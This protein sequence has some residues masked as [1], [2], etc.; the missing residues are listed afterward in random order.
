M[1]N[2]FQQDQYILSHSGQYSIIK[3]YLTIIGNH[4]KLDTPDLI[5]NVTAQPKHRFITWL[6]YQNKFLTRE[7]LQQLHIP[8]NNTNCCMCNDQVDETAQYLFMEYSWSKEVRITVMQW[9]GIQLAR[10]DV[11]MVL[12]SIKKEKWKQFKKEIVAAI[13]E[14][15]IYHTWKARN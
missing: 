13:L 11:A 7:I 3:S 2:W 14:A 6:A 1:Q 8:V 15:I 12:R 10:G 5:W 9:A 4:R